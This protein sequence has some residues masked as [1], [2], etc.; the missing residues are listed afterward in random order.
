MEHFETL[1]IKAESVEHNVPSTES[2]PEL[3]LK[4]LPSHLQYSYIEAEHKLL[5]I[6]ATDLSGEQKIYLLDLLKKHNK[7]IAWK[8]SNM[9][10]INPIVCMHR[11]PWK[12]MPRIS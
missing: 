1:E 6:I 3:E 9:K 10:Q 8:I 11:I 7:A 2:P 12:R 5:V 4:Q